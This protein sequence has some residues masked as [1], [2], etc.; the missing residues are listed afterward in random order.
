MNIH[1]ED[2]RK[3]NGFSPN[4]F[5]IG[6]GRDPTQEEQLSRYGNVCYSDERKWMSALAQNQKAFRQRMFPSGKYP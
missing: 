2:F 3:K 5:T 1:S 6:I 4:N